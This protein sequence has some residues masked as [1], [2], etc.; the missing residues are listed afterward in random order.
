MLSI[1]QNIYQ[2]HKTLSFRIF[3]KTA[4]K[5]FYSTMMSF[6]KRLLESRKI[7]SIR[8]KELAMQPGTKGPAIGKYERGEMKPS[9]EAAAKMTHILD[10]SLDWLVRH[11]DLELDKGMIRRIE[12]VTTMQV[13]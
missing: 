9:I 12:E 8:Q 5:L 7:K 3:A 13:K 6:D 10:V 11:T 4:I 2:F 1:M